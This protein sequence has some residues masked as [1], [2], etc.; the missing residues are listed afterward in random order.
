MAHEIRS[1]SYYARPPATSGC[2]RPICIIGTYLC[3]FSGSTRR[4]LTT[5]SSVTP[6]TLSSRFNRGCRWF[7]GGVTFCKLHVLVKSS[8]V[9]VVRTRRRRC[10]IAV[11]H[12]LYLEWNECLLQRAR[13]AKT[14]IH[15]VNSR[16][17]KELLLRWRY[18]EKTYRKSETYQNNE[19]SNFC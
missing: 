5:R 7:F 17:C 13:A 1:R 2:S 8:A 12:L 3:W 11:H 18:A 10:P 19:I 16:C 14:T 15:H 6:I 4:I 9:V